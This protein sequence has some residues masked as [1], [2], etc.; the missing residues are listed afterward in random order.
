M[1]NRGELVSIDVFQVYADA[2]RT[3][4]LVTLAGQPVDKLKAL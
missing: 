1:T 3:G 4:L 2:G